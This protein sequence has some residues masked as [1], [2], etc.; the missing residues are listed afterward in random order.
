MPG[1][2]LEGSETFEEAAAQEAKE[3]LGFERIDPRPLLE[4][5][6]HVV[7]GDRRIS[8]LEHYFPIRLESRDLPNTDS[9]QTAHRHEGIL[10]TRWWDVEALGDTTELI[11]P[12]EL[13]SMLRELG[14]SRA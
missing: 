8:Q 14:L 4:R 11:F 1:G 3:E 7:S 6:N 13:P 10:A 12:E 2:R 9:V 5:M